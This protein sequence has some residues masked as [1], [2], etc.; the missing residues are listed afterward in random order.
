MLK[1]R[2]M[3][4][5]TEESIDQ[6]KS[7]NV[8][9]WE[10][11]GI[12]ILPVML[13]A[14]VKCCGLVLRV[15]AFTGQGTGSWGSW[16]TCE[17]K[18]VYKVGFISEKGKATAGACSGAWKLLAHCSG[19]GWGFYGRFNW[20]WVRVR[21]ALFIGCGFVGF[22]RWTDLFAPFFCVCVCEQ[23][24]KHFAHQPCGRALRPCIF[25]SGCR[26]ADLQL[27]LRMQES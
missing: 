18:S 12:Y 25:S 15:L 26:N 1:S 13:C 27:L 10:W 4:Q 7:P 6:I 5:L 9:R 17:P 11:Q 8:R 21:W 3:K 2:E 24:W 22:P 20:V 19:E 23:S 16:L 14:H